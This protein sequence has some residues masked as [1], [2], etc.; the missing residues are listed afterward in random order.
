LTHGR[1][2]LT[3]GLSK[4]RRVVVRTDAR[5]L[6]GAWAA[7]RLWRLDT[8]A[9]ARLTLS[10]SHSPKC[11]LLEQGVRPVGVIQRAPGGDRFR[12][13]SEEWHGE[14]C[15]RA[16][17]LGWHLEFRRADGTQPALYYS[18]RTLLP[19]GRLRG[20]V[21]R[22]DWRLAARPRGQIGRIAFRLRTTDVTDHMKYVRFG[23]QAADEPL[24]LAVMLAASVA[25]L[26]HAD[27][28]TIP[29]GPWP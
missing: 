17:L 27:L 20:P 18:P 24:L 6:P 7:T 11:W 28:A 9:T 25:I 10:P 14:L 16:R 5:E 12:T 26:V 22:A 1:R 4:T 15:R 29:G 13:I 8:R 2:R 21:L 23:E 3:V 19:G